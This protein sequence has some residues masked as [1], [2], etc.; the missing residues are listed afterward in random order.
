VAIISVNLAIINIF[1]LPA[2][3]G[4]RILVALIEW[5]RGKDLPQQL[6]GVVNTAGIIFLLGLMA[7]ITIGDIIKIGLS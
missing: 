3:D 1:P 4:G 7:V 5:A 2:L 6:V